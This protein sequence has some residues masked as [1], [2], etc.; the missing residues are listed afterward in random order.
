M[1]T[2]KKKTLPNMINK[3]KKGPVLIEC[4]AYHVHYFRHTSNTTLLEQ[5][6]DPSFTDEKSRLGEMNAC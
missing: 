4:Q 3:Q 1:S 5:L 6:K 2:K